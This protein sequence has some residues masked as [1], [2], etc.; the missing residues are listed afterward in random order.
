MAWDG[1]SLELFVR[2]AT[3]GA[4]G[5]AGAELGLSPTAATQRIKNLE[6]DLGAQL[7]H[8]TT[9]AVS[10]TTEGENFLQHAQTI[11]TE[12][13][14]ARSDL[15]GSLTEAT[16]ELKVTASAV[17]GERFIVPY[18]EEFFAAFPGISVRLDLSDQ[19][20]NII[21]QGFD[22]AI[23]VGALAPS[24]LIARRLSHNPRLL[25][26]SPA[27][28]AR[29]G[30]PER[31]Q[32]LREHACIMLAGQRSWEFAGPDG[33]EH[34][35]RVTG[36]LSSNSGSAI[37]NALLADLGIATR[38]LWDVE[39]ALADGSLVPVLPDYTVLPEWKVWAVRPPGRR[40]PAR[41]RAF[42]GFLE[43]V[44]RTNFPAGA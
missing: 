30:T 41:V 23:R 13:D 12:M 42:T 1:I 37:R 3:L 19:I 9:R 40:A 2:A 6:T 26:A 17:F 25:A 34:E 18:I 22:L 43:N 4:I 29:H 32:D 44:I 39:F 21:E 36:R 28:L 7:L 10:L 27:Y 24:T 31:P 15:T 8:R 20:V 5:R 11:L 14:E 33:T 16:G 38:S 35:V